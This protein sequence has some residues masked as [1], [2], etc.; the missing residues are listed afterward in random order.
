MQLLYRYR[1]ASVGGV[2]QRQWD[3]DRSAGVADVGADIETFMESHLEFARTS[4]STDLMGRSSAARL[5]L[6]DEKG[7]FR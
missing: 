7:M 3:V 5:A 4:S 6:L 1:A 2:E